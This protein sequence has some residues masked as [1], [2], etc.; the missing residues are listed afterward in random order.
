M[1]LKDDAKVKN[2]EARKKEFKEREAERKRRKE[3]K[4]EKKRAREEERVEEEVER[5]VKAREDGER[6]DGYA[7]VGGGSASGTQG[8]KRKAEGPGDE[9][10]PSDDRPRG[11]GIDVD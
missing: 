11:G 6:M 1:L 5:R 9:D 4:K 7:Q 2:A 10:R 3:E 8:A